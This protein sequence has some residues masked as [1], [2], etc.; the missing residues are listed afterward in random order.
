MI[1]FGLETDSRE[2]PKNV[3]LQNK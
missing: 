1:K 2:I 3:K